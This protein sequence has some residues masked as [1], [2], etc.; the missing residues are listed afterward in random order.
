MSLQKSSSN[1]LLASVIYSRQK[2]K[3][4][5]QKQPSSF[6]FV[7]T[8]SPYPLSMPK[9]HLQFR[10]Q[11]CPSF[12][13]PP[14]ARQ[15]RFDRSSCASTRPAK[16]QRPERLDRVPT[17]WRWMES[18]TP[19]HTSKQCAQTES[20]KRKSFLFFPPTGPGGRVFLHSSGL[21][22]EYQRLF[23]S[24]VQGCPLALVSHVG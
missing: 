17:A 15:K 21:C 13:H 11:C 4:A 22:S 18:N 23:H 2:G 20:P 19:K 1:T 12:P 8:T 9:S 14:S 5:C 3:N 7:P 24:G 16:L 6:Y 10:A